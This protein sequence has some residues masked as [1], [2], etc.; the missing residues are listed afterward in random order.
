[1]RLEFSVLAQGVF[2]AF[3]CF[4]VGCNSSQSNLPHLPDLAL[5][6]SSDR[7]SHSGEC[8]LSIDNTLEE[9][10]LRRLRHFEVNAYC[11]HSSLIP[12]FRIVNFKVEDYQYAVN[13]D[14]IFINARVHD[15]PTEYSYNYILTTSG[16]LVIGMVLDAWEFGVKHMH[17]AQGRD[18]LAA[19]ELFVHADFSYSFNLMSGTFIMPIAAS[20]PEYNSRLELA[21]QS[22][23]SDE[24]GSRGIFLRAG[25]LLPLSVQPT[26]EEKDRFCSFSD[27]SVRNP[28]VCNRALQD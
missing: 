12:F 28:Q 24:F 5:A 7:S 23:F 22:F 18:V 6:L 3:T 26:Q 15:L 27:F 14:R 16:E 1:M 25:T 17:L 13:Q 9:M 10:R 8:R 2:I 19:G 11:A 21:I 4:H 20:Y